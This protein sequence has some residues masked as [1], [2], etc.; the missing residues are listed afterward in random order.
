MSSA[1]TKKE[2]ICML[3]VPTLD[4]DC[5]SSSFSAGFL[6]FEGAGVF[7]LFCSSVRL[8]QGLYALVLE[9]SFFGDPTSPSS[10]NSALNLWWV[11]CKTVFCSSLRD[12]GF[13]SFI[14]FL[15]QWVSLVHWDYKVCFSSPSGLRPFFLKGKTILVFLFFSPIY[16]VIS[17]FFY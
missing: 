15:L 13:F 8:R 1:S 14:L 16:S 10:F 11:L 7:L 5:D 12:R 3:F 4:I 2:F 9:L 6:D 17:Y